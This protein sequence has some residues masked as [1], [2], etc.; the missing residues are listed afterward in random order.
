MGLVDAQW[1]EVGLDYQ[2]RSRGPL[3]HLGA[4]ALAL[5]LGDTR[6]M[7]ESSATSAGEGRP[8][9]GRR[10]WG[11]VLAGVAASVTALGGLA[12]VIQQGWVTAPVDLDPVRR[13]IAALRQEIRA[14]DHARAVRDAEANLVR[15]RVGELERDINAS[16][17]DRQVLYA[18]L[19]ALRR[20]HHPKLLPSP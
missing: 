1:G 6:L 2:L 3:R 5:A 14:H 10:A 20:E 15:Q 13:D 16:R 11:P 18:G 19:V 7:I 9:V 17:E 8:P 12:A 4:T